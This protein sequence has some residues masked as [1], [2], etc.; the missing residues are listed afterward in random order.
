MTIYTND[1]N[2]QKIILL[3]QV[4]TKYGPISQNRTSG[5][6][7]KPT[8]DERVAWNILESLGIRQPA[9]NESF[10]L[11]G[12]KTNDVYF[13]VPIEYKA[14]NTFKP[15]NVVWIHP[16][17][18][19]S[20]KTSKIDTMRN[21]KVISVEISDSLFVFLKNHWSE[22]KQNMQAQRGGATTTQPVTADVMMNIDDPELRKVF[23][24]SSPIIS[25]YD[26]LS[27][28]GEKV[29]PKSSRQDIFDAWINF[30][31]ISKIQDNDL[32]KRANDVVNNARDIIEKSKGWKR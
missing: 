17:K 24:I 6:E 11:V 23:G 31:M 4:G 16:E 22:I 9:M 3:K 18:L 26:L 2:G 27:L 12:K 15:D 28:S 14:A 5:A 13:F 25:A 7:T 20:A 21:K 19:V 1:T 29:T 10:R 32:K 30:G 8:E